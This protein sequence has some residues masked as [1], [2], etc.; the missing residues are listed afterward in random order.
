MG[1]KP[2]HYE[3]KNFELQRAFSEENLGLLAQGLRSHVST[4]EDPSII[5]HSG[6]HKVERIQKALAHAKI[7]KVAAEAPLWDEDGVPKD[8]RPEDA[9]VAAANKTQSRDLPDGTIVGANDVMLFS[10]R[11]ALF[12]PQIKTIRERN[13]HFSKV[14]QGDEP[15]NMVVRS[16]IAAHRSGS[17]A[18]GIVGESH[19]YVQLK[20]FS[21][22]EIS[23]YLGSIK[24][25][26]Y[27]KANG[28]ILWEN[29]VIGEHIQTING[30]SRFDRNAF[31]QEKASMLRSLLGTPDCI[32]GVLHAL[33]SSSPEFHSD[34]A[35]LPDLHPNWSYYLRMKNGQGAHIGAATSKDLAEIASMYQND[36]KAAWDANDLDR[37]N[38]LLLE[39]F[40]QANSMGGI[41]ENMSHP[42]AL[43]QLVVR[44]EATNA[45]IG[46]ASMRKS[47]SEDKAQPHSDVRR[48]HISRS[49][50]QNGIGKAL[51]RL[52][53]VISKQHGYENMRVSA[54]PT[55]KS[56][57]ARQGFNLRAENTQNF[58][59]TTDVAPVSQ[60]T[61]RV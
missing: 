34:Q 10:G 27:L 37:S 8:I 11:E 26:E 39:R 20:P 16:A 32:F 14:L 60:L 41:Y 23:R 24:P 1:K 31:S 47:V 28:G 13:A 50:S 35:L 51:L 2:R 54:V 52:C 4:I 46:F 36:F 7:H 40:I 5:I 55:A 15:K 58:S 56:F 12:K 59:G 42:D 44:D 21:R 57:F 17:N 38:P 48:F 19:H 43:S 6:G 45:V 3:K 61:A 49:H 25:K 18:A 30:V 53:E 9:Y 33:L 22:N 29:P